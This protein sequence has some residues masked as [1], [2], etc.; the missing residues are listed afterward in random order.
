MARPCP[1]KRLQL[2]PPVGEEDGWTR[3]QKRRRRAPTPPPAPDHRVYTI[4]HHDEVSPFHAVRR[5]ER[6]HPGLRV[7][8]QEKSGGAIYIK[9]L[10]EEAAFSLARLSRETTDGINLGEVEGRSRGI[11]SRYPLGQSLRPI[12]EDPRVTFARRC[13][14]NAGHCR[15]EPTRQVEVTFRGSLPSSLDLG[16][17]GVFSVRRFTP[18]PLRCFNCQAFG[19]VQKYCRTGALCGVCSGKHPSSKCI[20]TLRTGNVRAARC[21][22]CGGRHHAWFKG[23]PERLRRLP[24]RPSGAIDT[25]P[26]KNQAVSQAAPSASPSPSPRME[27]VVPAPAPASPLP[28]F[29]DAATTT[30]DAAPPQQDEVATN[31]DDLAQE[32]AETQTSWKKRG[33]ACQTAPPPTEDAAAQSA[34]ETAAQET[35]TLRTTTADA[36][37][38]APD[39]SLCAGPPGANWEAHF[40]PAVTLTRVELYTML[41]A[42]RGLIENHAEAE[43]KGR[44]HLYENP[45]LTVLYEAL[46]AARTH[47][48][49]GF[50]I[51]CPRRDPRRDALWPE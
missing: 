42:L 44:E 2:S 1:K 22:N 17:W 27:V 26:P 49:P 38:A 3:V 9:P 24:P 36:E 23:C 13:T 47:R 39:P 16:V 32:D 43:L 20:D 21:P 45:I 48:R 8:V 25:L 14:Y 40:A 29:E 34:P 28:T 30:D 11:V 4:L 33:R 19:H 5:L 50:P 10:D 35:Q 18:E 37:T 6:E 12:Q 7:R 46:G 31:T 51:K 15:R 41:R